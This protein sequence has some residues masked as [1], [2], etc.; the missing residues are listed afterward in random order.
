MRSFA[1]RRLPDWAIGAAAVVLIASP[2]LLTS[3]GF[4]PDL[5][6]NI[7]LGW[8]NSHELRHSLAPPLFVNTAQ[9]GIFNPIFVFYGGPLFFVCGVLTRWFGGNVFA[10]F[11]VLTMLGIAMAYGGWLWLGHLCGLRGLLAHVPPLVTV[12]GAYYVTELYARG[13]WAEFMA[14]SAVPLLCASGA[15]LLQ[16]RHWRF[17][18]TLAFVV[19][20]VVFSGSHNV[21]L[22]WVMPLIAITSGLLLASSRPA[23][24]SRRR[25][26]EVLALFAVGVT[27][28][29]WALT[30]VLLYGGK[31]P[32]A[33]SPALSTRFFDTPRVLF[34]PL[35]Y[36]P[37][38]STTPRLFVQLPVWFLA[39]AVVAALWMWRRRTPSFSARAWIAVAG[40]M[41]ALVALILTGAV[42]RLPKP[43]S[44][45]QFPYRVV[46]YVLLLSTVLLVVTLRGVQ[47]EMARHAHGRTL[48]T[49]GLA[50][51]VA[52]SLGLTVWQ[53]WI[54]K[55]RSTLALTDRF[56][57]TQSLRAPP[58]SWYAVTDYGPGT[59]RIITVPSDR[60]VQIDPGLVSVSGSTLHATLSLPPGL[61]PIGTNIVGG[62]ELVRIGGAIRRVGR[63]ADGLAV[64][65]RRR[66]GSRPVRVGITTASS[67]GLRWGRRLSLAAVVTL[68]V[69]MVGL[70][71]KELRRRRAALERAS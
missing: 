71:S 63:T 53:L 5:T 40:V 37:P 27:V 39:W 41:S 58:A 8:V 47:D 13:D 20:T 14:L 64:V 54:P 35:R 18:P 43:F 70:A 23:W 17:G 49:A 48:V 34:D 65:A 25:V 68:G 21:T 10:A 1:A 32:I 52:V 51:A 59:G 7:W 28:N 4:A 60:L 3:D 24:L 56:A 16:E 11:D 38:Q 57:A 69:L 45:I 55:S 67:A 42:L 15:S 30:S 9:P 6:N 46:G 62:P 26:V 22:L 29:A 50:L 19:A 66:P 12:T 33:G 36:A 31:S 2:M 61:A 44:E